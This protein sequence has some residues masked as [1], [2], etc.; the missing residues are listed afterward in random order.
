LNDPLVT[1]FV[2]YLD[3]LPQILLKLERFPVVGKTIEVEEI[4]LECGTRCLTLVWF[5]QLSGFKYVAFVESSVVM[6][7]VGEAEP[8]EMIFAGLLFADHVIA[9]YR[10]CHGFRLTKRNDYFCIKMLCF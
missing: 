10:V 1:N 8:A 4:L 9:S 5:R 3:I 6:D 2:T 7:P